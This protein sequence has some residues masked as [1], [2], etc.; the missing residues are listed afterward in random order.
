MGQ[1]AALWIRHTFGCLDFV[2]TG[3]PSQCLDLAQFVHLGLDPKTYR[4]VCVKSTVHYR[5]ASDQI[6]DCIVNVVKHR[7]LPCK[8]SEVV[9]TN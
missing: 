2:V 1:T 3:I 4:A 5:V 7:M 8:L 6:C 9:F